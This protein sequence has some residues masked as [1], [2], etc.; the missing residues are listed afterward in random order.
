MEGEGGEAVGCVDAGDLESVFDGDGEA[1]EWADGG[2]GGVKVGVEAAGASEGLGEERLGETARELLG[3]CGALR[4]C[5]VSDVIFR[6]EMGYTLQNA[7]VTSSAVRRLEWSS[8]RR[9]RM[10]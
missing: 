8:F 3:N 7:R 4:R 9:E 10:S 2:V 1:V 6:Y 5:R